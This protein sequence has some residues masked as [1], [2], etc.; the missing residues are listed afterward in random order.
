MGIA[1]VIAIHTSVVCIP[2]P[3]AT[4]EETRALGSSLI[5]LVDAVALSLPLLPGENVTIDL[6]NIS[7]FYVPKAIVNY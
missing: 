4:Q 3:T 6:G 7:E 2:T 5:Q 1:L